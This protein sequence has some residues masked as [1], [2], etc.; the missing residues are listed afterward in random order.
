TRKRKKEIGV[1]SLLGIRKKE[2]GKMLFYENMLMGLLSLV[3]GIVIGSLLSKGFLKL[4]LNM[5]ELH[6]NVH[7]E[8]PVGAVIDTTV[9][10]CLIIL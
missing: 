3:I 2:I 6:V 10:F 4:L 8:V 7:F 9:I 1:Y 5:L